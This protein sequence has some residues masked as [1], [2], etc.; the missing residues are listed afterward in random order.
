MSTCKHTCSKQDT[1]RNA[2]TCKYTDIHTHTYT[3]THTYAHTHTHIYTHTHTQTEH[4]TYPHL[5]HS[6]DGPQWAQCTQRSQSSY[7]CKPRDRDV[8][9]ANNADVQEV[10]TYVRKK[11]Y[12]QHGTREIS[13]QTKEQL[14]P[15][16]N[17][18][19]TDVAYI[20]FF[21]RVP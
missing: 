15:G 20:I 2:L 9:R 18:L 10:P 4:Q 7:V 13:I 21:V 12:S 1:C 5:L 11:A 16:C 14:S 17:I 6:R 3:H 8:P 19:F